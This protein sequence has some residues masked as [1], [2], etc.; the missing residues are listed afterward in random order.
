MIDHHRVLSAGEMSGMMVRN[1]RGE[2]LANIDELVIDLDGGIV[3][4]AILAEG[5]FLGVGDTL[6]AVPWKA[7]EYSPADE[8]F[9]LDMEQAQLETGP[10]FDRRHW[11]QMSDLKWSAT[12][13]DFFGVPAYWQ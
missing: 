2:K 12:V 8:C 10:H 9:V 7:L 3:R 1:K 13:H 11:P 5:G 6:I 4:Y